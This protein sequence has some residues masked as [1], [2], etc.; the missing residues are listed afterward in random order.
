MIFPGINLYDKL[1]KEKQLEEKLLR[2]AKNILDSETETDITVLRRLGV[3]AQDPVNH[4]SIFTEEPEKIFSIETIRTICI[5]YR[6]RFLDASLFRSGYPY[7]AVAAIKQFEKNYGLR[8][9]AFYILAPSNAFELENVNKDPLL[10]VKLNDN[11]YYLIHQWGNDLTWHRNIFSWP[12]RNFKNLLITIAVTCF[13][14]AF[15]LPSD[16]MNVLNFRSEVYLR[17]WLAIHTFIGVLGITIWIGFSF[18]KS[19]SDAKWD[20]KYYN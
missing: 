11:S 9:W 5:Q 4:T 6:L 7:S 18:N 2:E 16:I 8:S 10:F 12:L 15:S 14:F 19:L 3:K 13:L 20:S 1:S 17:I